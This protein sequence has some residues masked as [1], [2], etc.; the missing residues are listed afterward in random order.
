LLMAG[1]ALPA[2]SSAAS[3]AAGLG[4]VALIGPWA[5]VAVAALA[6][7]SMFIDW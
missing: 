4:P 7:G 6:I 1:T 3:V 2:A 5:P